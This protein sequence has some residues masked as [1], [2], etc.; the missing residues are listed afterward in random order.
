[1]G[2]RLAVKG[3]LTA[4]EIPFEPGQE[5]AQVAALLQ[6]MKD[7]AARAGGPPP[8]P[9]APGTDH[10]DALAVLA[11]NQRF[12]AVGDDHERLNQDLDR[13][14]AADHQ[15]EK[16]ESSWNELQRLYRHAEGLPVAATL[17]PAI[18]A[19]REGRQLLDDPDPTAPL[20]AD[21]SA[22]LR[23]ELAS[24]AV[25]L[26]TAQEAA[27]ADLVS[28]NDWDRLDPGDQETILAEA[29]LVVG[30]SPDVSTDAALLQALDSAS[31]AAWLDR[32]SLVPGRRD[33]ARQRAATRIE[34][35]SVTVALPS[36]TVKS[37]NDLQLYLEEVRARVQPHIDAKKTVII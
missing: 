18:S 31:L 36:A 19:I 37:T 2:Q 29:Q 21:L 8:L 13:W 24:R 23:A 17:A 7:L 5:G 35:E 26:A 30:E 10:I 3:L 28:W 20:L 22:A 25:Q 27:V 12:R 14:R 11:G 6:R 9:D 1:V 16:R 15:R 33:Q 4:A 34:P 32:I